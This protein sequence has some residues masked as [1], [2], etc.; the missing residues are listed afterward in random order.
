MKK[1]TKNSVLT[2]KKINYSY[3]N[4]G[5]YLRD[6][7]DYFLNNIDCW[8]Y[9]DSMV[10]CVLV[11]MLVTLILDHILEFYLYKSKTNYTSIS[12]FCHINNWLLRISEG[13]ND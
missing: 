6:C 3:N 13:T 9:L 2:N 5:V 1:K 4:I 7:M 12:F 8:A 10:V 11:L